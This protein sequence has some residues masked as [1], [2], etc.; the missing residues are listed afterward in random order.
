M[1][2]IIREFVLWTGLV[3]LSILFGGTVYQM[4][5]IVPEFN[6]DIPN[7]MIGFVQGH[8]STVSFW[9]SSIQEFA[10]LALIAA[11]ILNWKNKRRHWLLGSTAFSIIATVIT[12]I[13]AVP[14]LQIMGILDGKPS[15]DVGLLS[16]TIKSFTFLDQLRFYMVIVPSFLM[17]V[18]AITIRVE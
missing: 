7:G 2:Q 12:I 10:M 11:I 5:V 9:G 16:Q 8:I 14:Q 17:Y 13:F 1:K 3:L 6:R 15:T 18:K 4:L